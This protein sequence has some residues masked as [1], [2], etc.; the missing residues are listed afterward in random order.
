MSCMFDFLVYM[1]DGCILLDDEEHTKD[2]IRTTDIHV[3][4]RKF[5]KEERAKE[6]NRILRCLKSNASRSLFQQ[7]YTLYSPIWV[8]DYEDVYEEVCRVKVGNKERLYYSFQDSNLD[9]DKDNRTVKYLEFESDLDNPSNYH[10]KPQ[11]DMASKK[12]RRLLTERKVSEDD[13]QWVEV[14]T[15]TDKEN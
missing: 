11:R 10:L 8:A 5:S 15:A 6:E 3:S 2:T 1:P 7:G 13:G 14:Y 9:A 12:V 4:G